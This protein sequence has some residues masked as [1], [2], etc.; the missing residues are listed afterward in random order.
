MS[1]KGET[2]VGNNIS[3]GFGLFW[4]LPIFFWGDPDLCDALIYWLMK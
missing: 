2:R 4:L 1:E 3:F